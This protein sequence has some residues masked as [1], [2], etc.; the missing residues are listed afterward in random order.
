MKVRLPWKLADTGGSGPSS[1]IRQFSRLVEML[2]LRI[3]KH[4]G[5]IR[6]N[7]SS[8]IFISTNQ[9]KVWT[10]VLSKQLLQA[11]YTSFR[12]GSRVFF[13]ELNKRN[14]PVSIYALFQVHSILR[15]IIIVSA[16]E[17]LIFVT[18]SRWH[19][20][21]S[22]KRKFTFPN[23]SVLCKFIETWSSDAC[24]DMHNFLHVLNSIWLSS[25]S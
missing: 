3:Q 18:S 16:H 22:Q 23:K 15:A 13:S 8:N 1:R 25:S 9:D 12:V 24:T 20:I 6:N 4:D 2:I 19:S 14:R 5:Q 10:S 11:N 7:L 17:S 21:N